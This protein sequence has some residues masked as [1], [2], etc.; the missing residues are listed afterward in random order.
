MAGQL[1]ELDMKESPTEE[2]KALAGLLA[3]LVADYDD[4]HYPVPEIL[5]HEMVA[6]LSVELFI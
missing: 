3:K 6:Y 5:P 4:L 2:E 1:E